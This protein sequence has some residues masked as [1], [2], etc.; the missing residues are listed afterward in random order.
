MEQWEDIASH[1]MPLG[2]LAMGQWGKKYAEVNAKF[3]FCYTTFCFV[4]THSSQS[5]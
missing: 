2:A 4:I 5:G 3:W 1:M